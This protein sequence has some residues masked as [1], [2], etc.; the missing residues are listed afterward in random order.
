MNGLSLTFGDWQRKRD[1]ISQ[2]FVRLWTDRQNGMFFR[3]ENGG[4]V[5]CLWRHAGGALSV[6]SENSA[7]RFSIQKHPAGDAGP[8]CMLWWKVCIQENGKGRNVSCRGIA[9][10]PEGSPSVD[11]FQQFACVRIALVGR[12]LQPEACSGCVFGDAFMAVE[13]ECAEDFLG[14]SVA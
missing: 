9:F 4:T 3:R 7:E 14:V 5:R 13:V 2:R 10:C 6:H 1:A 8:V 11:L 12:F